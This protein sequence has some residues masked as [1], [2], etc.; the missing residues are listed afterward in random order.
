MVLEADNTTGMVLEA[1]KKMEETM[2]ERATRFSI[3]ALATCCLLTS[4]ILIWKLKDIKRA[5]VRAILTTSQMNLH[6][7]PNPLAQYND[8]F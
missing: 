2:E 6:V 3:L 7:M 1:D 8:V 4:F 5:V